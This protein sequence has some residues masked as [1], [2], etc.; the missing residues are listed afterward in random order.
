MRGGN[1]GSGGWDG[2]VCEG[3]N[4]SEGGGMK[5]KVR[6]EEDGKGLGGMREGVTNDKK[7][8]LGRNEE[9]WEETDR[10]RGRDAV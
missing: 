9:G 5:W 7:G 3:G 6:M 10:D 8:R 2:R 1:Q 4:G